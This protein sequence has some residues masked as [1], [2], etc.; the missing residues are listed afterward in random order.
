MGNADSHAPRWVQARLRRIP[1]RQEYNRVRDAWAGDGP[2]HARG[3]LLGVLNQRALAFWRILPGRGWSSDDRYC[4]GGLPSGP[5]PVGISLR[6][7]HCAL[8]NPKC[9]LFSH[10]KSPESSLD[11]SLSLPLSLSLSLSLS[12][13]LAVFHLNTSVKLLFKFLVVVR[14]TLLLSSNCL[15]QPG[16]FPRITAASGREGA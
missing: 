13:S 3:A 5:S 2:L 16:E 9:A 15:P 4:L 7:R 12:Q 14:S 8:L 11:L 1:T 6:S 10:F